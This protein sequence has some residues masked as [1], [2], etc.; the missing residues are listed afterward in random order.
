MR[1]RSR[2]FSR[3]AW[4]LPAN[5]EPGAW[6]EAEPRACASGI[7]ACLPKGL[8]YWLTDE[9][10]TVELDD[11]QSA[12]HKLVARRGRLLEQVRAWDDEAM[13]D[14]ALD[15]A[16]RAD[17]ILARDPSVADYV[18]DAQRLAGAGKAAVTAFVVARVAELADGAG[19][20]DAERSAQARW[21]VERLDLG[22]FS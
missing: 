5:G 20:Y 4:P 21:L 13:R 16:A 15:C 2:R 22:A 19:A 14:F 1:A 9:L 7:H 18:Q 8:P 3:L 10:W 6:V 12:E 17:A 11:V